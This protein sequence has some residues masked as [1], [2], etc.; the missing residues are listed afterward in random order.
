LCALIVIKEAILSNLKKDKI[1]VTYCLKKSLIQVLQLDYLS[2]I[3][4]VTKYRKEN[5]KIT[6]SLRHKTI[7]LNRTYIRYTILCINLS[8]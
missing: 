6:K 1:I 7:K 2:Q 4:I 5:N 8:T 3:S